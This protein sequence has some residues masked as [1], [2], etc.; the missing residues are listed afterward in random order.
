MSLITETNRKWWLLGAVSCVL[1]LVLLDETVVGI[2]LPTIQKEFGLS[3]NE[4]HWVV[5]AY[6]LTFACF[7][8]VGG[9]IADLFGILRVFLVGLALFSI[10][11]IACGFAPSGAFLI[12]ARALQGLGAAIIFPIFLAMITMTFK[13]EVR[14]AAI[15]T[16]GA[17]GTTF[18]ALGPLVGGLFTDFLSWRWVFWI[19]PIVAIAV[20]VIVTLT[21][22]DVKR[23]AGRRIDLLGLWLIATGMFCLVYVLMEAD[24]QG[25]LD[26][27][28]LAS[29]AA[30]IVFLSVFWR[31]ERSL[32]APLIEVDLFAS[33]VFTGS[34][35]TIFTAQYAKMP[36]FVFV[37]LYAQTE[38]GLS[39]FLAGVV[40]MLAPLLQ[41]GAAV[42][43]GRYA[44]K[45]PKRQQVLI[46]LGIL[47]LSFLWL[48]VTEAFN[49]V[50][51]FAP[52]LLVA[53]LAFPFLFTPTRAAISEALPEHK[54]GQGGGIAMTSQT[55]GGTVGL[56]VSSAAFA[57]GGYALVF[58]LTAVL[59]GLVFGY[60]LIAFRNV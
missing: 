10:C 56:A 15:A 7:V 57:L 27:L 41:P 13:K 25:W 17:V 4:A 42:V 29:F 37:A 8:A 12:G 1:G 23:P 38:L 36:L 20:A 39:P 54:H 33:P 26:P 16:S 35:L 46:G 58:G 53:G 60:A 11:S 21:W 5:N 19:N 45:I 14:G 30:G 18:L 51:L 44:D 50:Y 55:I 31:V 43:C 59:A 3:N 24:S 2:A 28:I 47:A 9:K 40:V 34:N 32:E 22:R 48:V 52:G 6:L 49:D